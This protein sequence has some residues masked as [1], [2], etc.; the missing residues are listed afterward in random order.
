MKRYIA[1]L[2]LLIP[3]ISLLHNCT[4]ASHN[5]LH[6]VNAT[7]ASEKQLETISFQISA[8]LDE[9]NK[10]FCSGVFLTQDHL[11]TA[12]HCVYGRELKDI[13]V[14]TWNT[15]L[16]TLDDFSSIRNV[17][18]LAPEIGSAEFPNF[19]LAVIVLN[20]P[21]RKN[22]HP[23]PISKQTKIG[24]N[25]YVAGFGLTATS[26]D[27]SDKACLGS[28]LVTKIKLL[29]LT[30]NSRFQNIITIEGDHTGP[31]MGDSGGPIFRKTEQGWY[32]L[33]GI[34]SGVWHVFNSKALDDPKNLCE[35]GSAIMTSI[36]GYRDWIKHVI[37]GSKLKPP[38]KNR[39][40]KGSSF[41]DWCLYDN[42]FDPT[43]RTT[44][45]LMYLISR[46]ANNNSYPAKQVFSD[47]HLAQEL[48]E[49][50]LETNEWL[51][52]DRSS[53]HVNQALP[54]ASLNPKKLGFYFNDIENMNFQ[55]L[56]SVEHLL[57][58]ASSI[59][60]QSF[61]TIAL[62]P[63][64]RLLELSYLRTKMELACLKQS[65]SLKHLVINGEQLDILSL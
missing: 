60:Q 56:N 21:L 5:N 50:W 57:L 40:Q 10:V 26:C 47:C 28:L 7:K 30:H 22:I 31:C 4:Q 2:A 24:S 44:Q 38:N 23:M 37:E 13:K 53:T 33:I 65:L 34:T 59:D 1:I 49:N 27:D 16:K 62:M 45:S 14:G 55:I 35:S 3:T 36:V 61:C 51:E 42:I 41:A 52:F 29:E 25:A 19:D 20:T 9:R 8:L 39:P 15:K 48:A 18:F 54:I 46:Y 17:E 43:W 11:L 6:I 63:N 64:L 58:E 12:A 32:E